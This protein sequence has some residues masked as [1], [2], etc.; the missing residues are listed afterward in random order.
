[1]HKVLIFLAT[2][3]TVGMIFCACQA[4]P[5]SAPVVYGGGLED[6]IKDTTAADGAYNYPDKWRE[7]MILSGGAEIEFDTVIR[8]PDVTAFPVYKVTPVT[9]TDQQIGSLAGYF[10]KGKDVFEIPE[11]TKT[12]LEMQLIAAKKNR[13][14]E[15]AAEI[16]AA[17][18]SAPETAEPRKIIDWRSDVSPTGRFLDDDGEYASV[19]GSADLFTYCKGEILTNGM[20]QINDM[21]MIEEVAITEEDATK[22]AQKLLAELGTGEMAADRL[23][24]AQRYACLSND[25]SAQFSDEA[26]SKG[27]LIRFV[28]NIGGLRG[29]SDTG[30]SMMYYD[31]YDYKAPIYPEEIWVYVNEAGVTQAFGWRYPLQI[32]EAITQNAGLLPFDKVKQ[33]IRDMLTYIDSYDGCPLKVTSIEMRMALVDVKDHPDEAMY[34]P[35]WF[36]SYTETSYGMSTEERLVLNAIDGG[37]ILELPMEMDPAIQNAMKEARNLHS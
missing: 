4:T 29:I 30:A 27:Y 20:L 36:I 34:A 8:V 18:P 25:Y 3:M 23:E 28:R 16:E 14:T 35:A 1:M 10:T 19:S 2:A 12:D 21:D 33:R 32:K 11:A 6:K 24:M 7:I 37:R 22:A 31:D 15:L 5:K 26:V 9:F 17:I 13:D